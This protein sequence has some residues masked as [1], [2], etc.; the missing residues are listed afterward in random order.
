MTIRNEKGAVVF[1]KLNLILPQKEGVEALGYSYFD[2][3]LL[4]VV[5]AT[6]DSEGNL[7]VNGEWKDEPYITEKGFG[8]CDVEF[9]Y[10]VPENALNTPAYCQIDNT[11]YMDWA[12]NLRRFS[13]STP[14]G[15]SLCFDPLC[16]HSKEEFCA[17][18]W[19]VCSVVTD[20]ERLYLK[21]HSYGTATITALNIDGSGRETLCEFSMCNGLVTN[22]STARPSALCLLQREKG[23]RVSGG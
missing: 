17:E 2:Q 23:D 19:N 18:M 6:Y 11:V 14:E 3:G 8:E 9:P 22:I 16:T 20:G 10:T 21:T 15:M 1:S 12:A 7:S 5:F 4:R 13:N